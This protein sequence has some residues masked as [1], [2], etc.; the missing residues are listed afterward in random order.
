MNEARALH[1][2]EQRAQLRTQLVTKADER[3]RQRLVQREEQRE[4]AIPPRVTAEA[5]EALES[6]RW[7]D[8]TSAAER[9]FASALATEKRLAVIS[10][11]ARLAVAQEQLRRLSQ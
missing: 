7:R 8:V 6:A 10:A 9:Q 3:V 1:D 11:E 2:A 5:I 4:A